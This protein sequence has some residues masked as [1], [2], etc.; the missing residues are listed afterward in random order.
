MSDLHEEAYRELQREYLA[1]LPTALGEL[2]EL[3]AA[4]RRGTDVAAELKTGFHRLAGSGGSYGFP[5]I[6]VIARAAEHQVASSLPPSDAEQLD[7]AVRRLEAA[8]TVARAKVVAGPTVSTGT[9]PRAVI[10]LPAG[11]DRERLTE[12]L[13]GAGF[14]VDLRGRTEDPLSVTGDRRVDLLVIGT[15]PGEG[16]PSAVASSW[17]SRRSTR[18]RAVILIETL[19]AVD[20]LRATAAGVD[21][22]FPAERMVADLPR[23]ART[24]AQCGPPPSTVLLLDHD[25]DR[26]TRMLAVLEPANIRVVRS[27][28]ARAARELLDREVP[29]LLT[30]SPRLADGDGFAVLREVR[31]DPRFHLLPTLVIG[32]PEPGTQVEALRAGADDFVSDLAP[33]ELLLQSVISRAERGRRLREMLLRDE[34][35][36]LLN[37]GALMGELE[38]AVDYGRRH[39]GPLTFV[40]F[41]LDRFS[42]VHER[43]GQIV[44]D[45][46]L[47]H[48]ANV[49]RSSVRASDVIGRYG[50][51]EFAMILRG[52]GPSGAA[53][54]AA[55]LR[56]VLGAHAASTAEGVIIPLHVSVGWATHPTDGTSAGE[57]AHAA[58]R[59]LRREKAEGR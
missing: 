50:A 30:V 27:P 1:E 55:K 19:R 53:V 52:A 38:Y 37:H 15:A 58:M 22:V 3:I 51:E 17:T 25:V 47:L 36:G 56:Q 33:P 16:D 2:R 31:E 40:L 23:Y 48:V 39:G 11:T 20:R 14:A 21:A 4:L 7:E 10:I 34:L 46:V 45:Q 32:V 12:A 59:A 42:E 13:V 54:V 44:G 28:S 24:L 6:S 41:D 43:F 57:L 49:F 29:D 18:P 5:E 26:S 35:T 9:V 8:L